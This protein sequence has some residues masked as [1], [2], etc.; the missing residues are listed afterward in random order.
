MDR[1]AALRADLER[2][3]AALADVMD[4]YLGASSPLD[5][6]EPASLRGRRVAFVGLGSSLF[7]SMDAAVALRGAGVASWAE[8]ASGDGAP[9]SSDLVLVAVSASGR[10]LEVVSVAE[11]HRGSSLVIGVTN[12]PDS[13]LAQASDVVLPLIAGEEGAGISTLTYRATVVVLGV[14]V[15]RFGSA[16]DAARVPAPTLGDLADDAVSAWADLLDGAPSIDVIGPAARLGAVS[17]AALM[18]REAPRLPAHAFETADWLHT[19][20]YLALP[21]HRAILFPGSPA[22]AEVIDTIRRRG[23]EV[24][25]LDPDVFVASATVDRLALELWRRV[26]A[27]G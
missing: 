13:P 26:S 20:V 21:G 9:P 8:Y 3:P 5:A 15:A 27:E 23:G 14:L 24:V 12:V 11:L 1:V 7:A 25:T 6:L 4:A 16:S 22:D 2:G 19:A 10:T 17:Q 18:L